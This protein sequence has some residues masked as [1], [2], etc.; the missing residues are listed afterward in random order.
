MIDVYYVW[1]RLKPDTGIVFHSK[2]VAYEYA[3]GMRKY[4]HDV[5]VSTLGVTGEVDEAEWNP[6]YKMEGDLCS[7][8]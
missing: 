8:D 5:I 6:E 2:T 4:G 1:E 7:T 3:Y